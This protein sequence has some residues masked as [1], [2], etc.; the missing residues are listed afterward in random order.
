[1]THSRKLI[2]AIGLAALVVCPVVGRTEPA[3]VDLR[4]AI[5]IETVKG[6]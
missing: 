1:M 6:D 2:T 3:E 4:A 5:E